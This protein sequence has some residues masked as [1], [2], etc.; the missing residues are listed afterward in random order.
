MKEIESHRPKKALS[1]YMIFV[2]ETRPIVCERYPQMHALEV[3]KEVGKAW[4]SL[5]SHEKKRFEQSAIVDK[6]RYHKEVKKFEEQYWELE[7]L[8]ENIDSQEE[9]K[10]EFNN[11]HLE[12]P[13]TSKKN[14]K[15]KE[16]K[17]NVINWVKSNIKKNS[18]KWKIAKEDGKPK[19]PLSAYIYF[20]QEVSFS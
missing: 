19:R 15:P 5:T 20:S 9:I 8:E 11:L 1:A 14:P 3:M 6:Q 4:Q 13:S 7:N 12:S 10:E 16:S 2:R 18:I 17:I